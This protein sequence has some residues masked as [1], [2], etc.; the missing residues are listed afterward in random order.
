MQ[1]IIHVQNTVHH[2]NVGSL[3]SALNRPKDVGLL[4]ICN[5][6]TTIDSATIVP[7]IVPLGTFLLRAHNQNICLILET[8]ALG[9]LELKTLCLHPQQSP[10][11]LPS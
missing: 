10:L 3:L 9:T 2:Y 8:A 5:H 6:V 1:N 11:V 7:S 4:T